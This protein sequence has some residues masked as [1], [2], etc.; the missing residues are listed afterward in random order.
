MAT[1]QRVKAVLVLPLEKQADPYPIDPA[2]INFKAGQEYLVTRDFDIT[3]DLGTARLSREGGAIMAD[4][5]LNEEGIQFVKHGD[6]MFYGAKLAVGVVTDRITIEQDGSRVVD[7]SQLYAA[8]LT[9]NHADPNQPK[10][11]WVDA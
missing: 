11:E 9:Y 5:T 2:G 3:T 6:K 4:I 7:K 8:S 10:V 1:D